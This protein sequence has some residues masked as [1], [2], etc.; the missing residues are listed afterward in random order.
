MQELITSLPAYLKTGS[1]LAYA[2]VFAGG[3]LVSF[4]PCIYPVIPITVGYIGSRSGGSRGRGFVFSVAYVSGMAAVYAALGGAAALTGRVFG[5]AASN[6]VSYLVVGNLCILFGLSL[7]DHV[8]IPFLSIASLSGA[9][10]RPG[11][12]LGAVGMG[13]ASGL[14]V[15]PCTAPVLGSLLLFVASRQNVL[16]GMTLLFLFALG[17]GSLLV[18]LGTFSGLIASLPRSGKWLVAV[19]RGFGVMMI[20]AGEYFLVQAGRLLV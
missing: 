16:Q 1:A 13:M 17:M 2:A 7:F 15:G 6:P 10:R 11:G 8:R 20:L 12:V 9:P 19:Q 3:M 14:V 4:T 5:E 18:L